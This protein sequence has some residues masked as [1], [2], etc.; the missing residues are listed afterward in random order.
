M[1]EIR[2]RGKRRDGGWDYGFLSVGR[3]GYEIVNTDGMGL[4]FH[5]PVEP[6]TVGQ[7]TGLK[8]KDGKEIY[9]G[10][11]VQQRVEHWKLGDEDVSGYIR[12]V[13]AIYPSKG[14]CIKNT[15]LHPDG[16]EEP[17]ELETPKR[18]YRRLCEVIGNIHDSPELLEEAIAKAKEGT[19]DA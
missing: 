10:D 13:V 8:D 2:F 16:D 19:K 18:L 17:I 6:E 11:V 9:E 12:G 7:F 4:F 15:W 5:C 1:R 3:D 14:V